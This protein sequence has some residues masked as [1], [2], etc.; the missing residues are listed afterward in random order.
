MDCLG[1]SGIFSFIRHARTFMLND[2]TTPNLSEI[3]DMP[4][5]GPLNFSVEGISKSP[6]TANEMRSLNCHVVI[7]NCLNNIQPHCKSPI[8]AWAKVPELRVYPSAGREMNAYYDRRSLRF[9][10]YPYRGKNVYF[11]D[12]ADIVTHEL[13]HAFLDAMRPDFWN[14]QSLEIWSFH[15]AFSDIV[16]MFNLMCY[17]KAIQVALE[18]TKGSMEGSNVIS[19]LAEEVGYMIRGVTENPSYLPNALRD[20]ALEHFNYIDPVNLP[21][22]APNEML[23]AECH[24]FGRVFSGAWYR[25]FVEFFKMHL[26]DSDPVSAFKIAR[27]SAFSILMHAIPPSPRIENYYYGIA[28]SMIAVGKGRN[29]RYGSI[30][31]SVFSEWKIIGPQDVAV[32][33]RSDLRSK[34]ISSLSKHDSV[35]KTE[36]STSVC[37]KNSKFFDIGELPLATSMSLGKSIKIEVPYDSYYEFDEFGGLVSQK[38]PDE[39]KSKNHAALC[40]M[41][42]ANQIGPSKMWEVDSGILN[43]QFVK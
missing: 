11:S 40:V 22:E 2:P 29:E 26:E 28:K 27:N 35:L 10:Y 13:G 24:S 36:K 20:P 25:I 5:K 17:E 8:R 33:S 1:I 30:I 43:R 41:R 34:I 31:S 15:E 7:G 42:I 32:Q 12:S 4:V 37:L 38:E 23:A 3:M 21:Q 19:K 6:E 14:V 39:E 16:A 9:F 18:Q